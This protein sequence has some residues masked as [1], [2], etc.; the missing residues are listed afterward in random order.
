MTERPDR[1]RAPL[2]LVAIG[3]SVARGFL[4]WPPRPRRRDGW[5][6]RIGG[7]PLWWF[8]YP[9]R[10]YP[11][12][13]GPELSRR[14]IGLR[15]AMLATYSGLR[16]DHLWRHDAPTPLLRSVAAVPA[17]F[18]TMTV[19]ANDVLPLWYPYLVG[20]VPLRL[21]GP[22]TP[23]RAVVALGHRLAPRRSRSAPAERGLAHRLGATVGWLSQRMPETRIVVTTYFS[24]D[25]TDL[26][27]ERFADPI[28]AVIA[29]AVAEHPAASVVD[30]GPLVDAA[31]ASG[32]P[33]PIAIDALHPTPHG[34]RLIARAIADEVARRVA[35]ASDRGLGKRHEPF[36]GLGGLD[37]DGT[38]PGGL[39]L[40]DVDPYPD[41]AADVGG[42][43]RPLVDD[44]GEHAGD[45]DPRLLGP[46]EDLGGVGE[47]RPG[48]HVPGD[49]VG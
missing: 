31:R 29:A 42:L 37:G 47:V 34:H 27:R 8:D 24:G 16:T 7:V 28:A 15:L 3:D 5:G 32:G 30:L 9:E 45:H 13:L 12:L 46:R 2:R 17:D 33:R 1:G 10:A 18:V 23:E 48:G 35:G 26:S 39:L 11:A 4:P 25:G 21:L 44:V 43:Q 38:E 6:L 49:A 22:L 20:T 40:R 19:G 41:G 36:E 14:G